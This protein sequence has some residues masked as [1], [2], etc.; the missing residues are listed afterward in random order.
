MAP[1]EEIK[2]TNGALRGSICYV[3]GVL[4][5]LLYLLSVS[6]DR[7]NRF[8]RFHCFQCL[9]LFALLLPLLFVRSGVLRYVSA[10]ACPLLLV[11]W[12]V[13]M[14]QARRGKMFHLLLLGYFADRLA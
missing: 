5:P 14:I 8:L 7:Q 2:P 10:L 3:F 1:N 13:A 12:I 4:F 11:G 9:F 6:R